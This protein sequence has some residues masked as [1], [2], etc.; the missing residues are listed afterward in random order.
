M[1]QYYSQI[2]I[3]SA[4]IDEYLDNYDVQINEVF[5]EEPNFTAV[6]GKLVQAYLGDQRTLNVNFEP[7]TTAQL[8]T[9]FKSI[10]AS[11][12]NISI[13][14][15]D[16]KDGETTKKFSCTSLP[17]AT[18]FVCD[19]GRQFWTIPTVTF[20]EVVDFSGGSG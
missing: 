15:I 14:Y 2:T 6:S 10:K 13:K 9:L 5:A 11:R 12:N 18:Y 20:E 17:A 16:P 7:M 8:N 3:N 19:D 4:V 1:R